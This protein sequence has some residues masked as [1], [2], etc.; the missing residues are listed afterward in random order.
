MLGE[1]DLRT[2]GDDEMRA[3]RGNEIAMTSRTLTSLYPVMKSASR[4]R[5]SC[6][7]STRASRGVADGRDLLARVGIDADNASTSTGSSFG[8]HAPARDDRDGDQRNLHVL[9]RR[10]QESA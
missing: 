8:R 1:K 9:I 7:T 5:W 4:S 2:I 3:V 10:A 6:S